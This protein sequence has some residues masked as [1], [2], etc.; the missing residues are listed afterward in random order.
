LI[1]RWRERAG[2]RLGVL[3]AAGLALAAASAAAPR[4]LA[5][6][7]LGPGDDLAGSVGNALP[8][9]R[10]CLAPGDHAGPLEVPDGV[11]VSGPR[12]ARIRAGADGTTVR[13]GGLGAALEG[14]T[15]DGSG[16]RF[17]LLDAAVLVTADDT[18]VERVRIVSALF[19]IRVERANRVVLRDNEVE[20]NPAKV[21]G[22]RGDGIRLWEVRG[23]TIEGNRMR[24]SRDLVVW[25]SPGNRFLGNRIEGGRYGTHFM[26]SHDNVARGNDYDRN[27]VGIFVMY[28]RRL[29]IEGNRIARAAGAAGIGVGLKESGDITLRGNRLLGNTV[30][31][32]VDTSPLDPSEHNRFEHNQIRFHDRAIVFHGGAD[33]NHFV[34]NELRDN[35]SQVVL[36]GRG[37]ARA[38]EWSGNLWDD[39]AGYDLDGDGV[40]DIPYQLRSLANEWIGRIPA[41]AFFRGSAALAAVEW[42]GAALPLFQP[43]TLLV[44]PAPRTRVTGGSERAH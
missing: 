15:V 9:T 32:Y 38:A 30:G 4:P 19:G 6:V 22:L 36:E 7:P 2:R 26:Y 8:G 16:A 27:V 37:D 18:R 44:D 34:A 24:D 31:L 25:Y 10:F 14:V 23:S 42:L 43:T 35:R 40:G 1:A 29:Q 41:L 28:S 17:D 20:G 13:L 12:D 33:R 5:C 39:Y 3:A 21:L 11:T